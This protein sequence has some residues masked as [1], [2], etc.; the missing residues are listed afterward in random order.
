MSNN[1][2]GLTLEEIVREGV[3]LTPMMEQYY[4]IKKQYRDMILMFRMGDFY[5]VFFEDAIETSKLLNISQTHRGK[6]GEHKIPMAG[7]PHHA[8]NAYVDRLTSQGKKVAICEQVEDPKAAKGIVKRAV[9]QVVSPGMP[10][11]L[12]RSESHNNHFI[13]CAF[14]QRKNQFFLVFIDFTTGEFFGMELSSAEEVAE[15]IQIYQPKEM[16]AFLGQWENRA[17]LQ[18]LIEQ[19]NLLVTH[20]SEE[21][22]DEKYTSLYIEKLI[23]AYKKDEIIKA[24]TGL[25]KPIGALSYYICS[26]QAFDKIS[27]FRPFQ[28]VNQQSEMKITYPTL[29]GLEIFPKTKESY[30]NS[31]LGFMDRTRTAMGA[32]KLRSV[33]QKPLRDQKLIE[34]R[35]DVV[36][37][38]TAKPEK[39]SSIR[40]ILFDIRDI[41]RILA[42]ASTGK[43]NSADMINLAAAYKAYIEL[44]KLLPLKRFLNQ[45]FDNDKL[46]V[47]ASEIEKTINDEVGCS[48]DKGNL[49]REGCHKQRDKLAKLSLNAKD[50][51]LA[52]EAKYREQTGIGNL[53]IKSN[54]VAG[55]FIEVSKSHIKKV[56]KDFERRQTLV[57]SERYQSP[58]LAEFEKEVITARDK[59]YKLERKIFEGIVSQINDLSRDLLIMSEN[60]AFI[61]IFQSFAWVTVQEDFSRPQ[62]KA[63]QIVHIKQAWHPLIKSSLKDR[64]V[65]HNLRLDDSVYF[66]LITG[67]N[68]AGKT[69]VMRE[70]AIIQFLAQLGCFVPA[71]NA[72]LGLTDYI[73][74]RLGAHDDIIKGQSTF[75]VEMSETAEIIRHATK[76]SLIILDEIGRG[77]STFDGLSIAWALVE[78]FIIKTKALTLFSTHYHELIDLVNS[79]P[80]SK[81]LTVKTVNSNGNVQ[82]LYE[83]IEEGA[84]QSFGIHVAKLA[85]LPEEILNRSKQILKELEATEHTLN[86]PVVKNKTNQLNLFEEEIMIEEKEHPVVEELRN[87]DVMNLTPLQ[88]LQKLD[89]LKATFIN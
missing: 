28:L 7:I 52:L 14:E 68:M 81:N 42:K 71:E 37:R 47:L 8:A 87:M 86:L 32:R 79:L 10:F 31:L 65:H 74:S 22:F 40:E 11:D 30:K 85:G 23:P 89:E 77:T 27:H 41:E 54:N 84:A 64:F 59:L 58:E 49:I 35:F 88:A 16:L 12:D 73:F 19:D 13:A 9:T 48:L 61:D 39:L 20:L 38:F 69:T 50:S 60:I 24:H 1:S 18:A 55:Y 67:P 33:F 43:I 83:L 62:I 45:K 5:E 57:N 29:V 66:G 44:E 51:L 34:E 70:V 46:S 63:Q 2:D 21:Y 72:V 26:T 75:M 17:S 82:F 80:Q 6:L 76:D 3:K 25:I 78:Y 36:E 56:P 4:E 15:K 53:K